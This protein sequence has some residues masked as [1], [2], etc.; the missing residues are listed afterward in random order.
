VPRTIFFERQ[1]RITIVSILAS[2][3]KGFGFFLMSM[4]ISTP[5][6]KMPVAPKPAPRQNSGK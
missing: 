1:E 3:R 5:A 2:L 6:K 4:G